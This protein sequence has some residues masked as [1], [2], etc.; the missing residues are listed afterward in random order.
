MAGAPSAPATPP[1]HRRAP[2]VPRAASTP[3]RAAR[4]RAAAAAAPRA[5]SA[6]AVFSRATAYLAATVWIAAA[7]RAAGGTSPSSARRC[8]PETSLAPSA[9]PAAN[10]SSPRDP[11][12]LSTQTRARARRTRAPHLNASPCDFGRSVI[13]LRS[14]CPRAAAPSGTKRARFAP[15]LPAARA[16][17]GASPRTRLASFVVRHRLAIGGS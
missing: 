10:A 13:K 16:R 2:R 9:A 14:T 5:A 1:H 15:A 4:R 8:R 6:A 11:P 12:P 3:R 17:R 7:R